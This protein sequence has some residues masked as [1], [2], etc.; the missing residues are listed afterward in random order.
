MLVVA[1]LTII[2]FACFYNPQQSTHGSTG[3]VA[4]MYGKSLTQADIDRDVKKYSLALALGQ[5]DLIGDLG[6]MMRDENASL[7]QFV[8]NLR[9]IKHEAGILGIEPALAQVAERVKAVPSFQTDGQFDPRKYAAFVQEHLGPRGFTEQQLEEV[10]ADSLRLERL[11]EVVASPVALSPAE[12]DEFLRTLQKMDIRVIS[13]PL[14]AVEKATEVSDLEIQSYY[15]QNAPTL[16][17][18][19][20]RTVEYVTFHLDPKDAAA[21]GREKVDALQKLVDSA[22]AFAGTAGQRPFGEAARAAGLTVQTTPA[23]DRSGRLAPGANDGADAAA[24]LAETLR[25]IAPAAFVLSP[26]SPVSDS[27]QVGDQFYVVRLASVTPERQLP[28]DE[29]RSS[30]QARLRTAKARDRVRRDAT[31]AIESLRS[32]LAAGKSIEAAAGELKLQTELISGMDVMSKDLPREKMEAAGVALQLQPGR[33]S[34]FLQS[35]DGGIAVYLVSRAPIS[36]PTAEIEAKKAEATSQM[37]EAKRRLLFL[38]WLSAARDSAGI[39]VVQR[40]Q[41]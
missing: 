16:R 34:G 19:E 22:S 17:A 12:T 24:Q 28:I 9:V 2:A 33:I 36:I 32:A 10:V 30:V 41:Q 21:E 29:V 5:Y 40:G 1:I 27:I 14:A 31:S 7:E 39:K 20:L 11:R 37:A 15:Q 8:W 4:T 26:E 6:G 13:F 23:F 3:V 38:S 35:A 25:A 18:P